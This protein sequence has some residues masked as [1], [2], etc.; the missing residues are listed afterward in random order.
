MGGKK[1]ILN[2]VAF[3]GGGHVPSARFR[4]RQY[5]EPLQ[6]FDVALNEQ[7]LRTGAYPPAGRIARPLWGVQRLSELAVAIARSRNADVTLL[8]REMMSSFKTLEGFTKRP[9]V[10]DVDD[11]V[12]LQRG[13]N[14]AR[15]I[16]AG[17]D[18]IIAGNAF[19]ADYYSQWNKDVVI[20][21]TGVDSD[22]YVP[23][24]ANAD[25]AE[26]VIG[27]IGTSAN[28]IYLRQIESALARFLDAVP[29]A[30]LLV[31]SNASPEFA[32]I[33]PTRWTFR[34]WSETREISDIQSM[35]IG[36]MPLADSEWARGKCSFKMLQ[37]MS[38]GL[39]VVVS[40]V[41]MNAD[42]LKQGDI[43]IGALKDADWIDGLK[44]LALSPD[45]RQ[46]LGQRG[47]TLV[48]QHYA[49]NALVPQFARH[50]RG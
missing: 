8:Q 6:Q 20:M 31:V 26:V 2:V 9:R 27:W 24:S 30:H 44:M 35:D 4:V 36:I 12:H 13:G 28:F 41:G 40:T 1:A 39:P 46:K 42:V 49:V 10:L 45:F 43:G 7:L 29:S 37:Y 17:C 32:A 33:A 47:R 16:A 5:R 11:A 25:A 19:L 3:T 38:C 22:T 14:F 15:K 23:A 34:P 48:E 21:P 50:L 18:R